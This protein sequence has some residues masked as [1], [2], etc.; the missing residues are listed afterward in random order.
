MPFFFE[1]SGS[2]HVVLD[3]DAYFA[4]QDI[5][6]TGLGLVLLGA[7]VRQLDTRNSGGLMSAVESSFKLADVAG[8]VVAGTVTIIP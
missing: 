1:R 6:G 5:A 8:H 3:T 7:P 4:K 2:L